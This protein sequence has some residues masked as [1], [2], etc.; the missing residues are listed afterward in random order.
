VLLFIPFPT[1]ILVIFSITAWYFSPDNP[2]GDEDH[3]AAETV[4]VFAFFLISALL[5]AF[6]HLLSHGAKMGSRPGKLQ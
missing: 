5:F 2:T 4:G 3:L 6:G 1:V